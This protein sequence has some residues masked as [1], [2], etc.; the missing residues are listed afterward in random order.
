MDFAIDPFE[1]RGHSRMDFA[2]DATVEVRGRRH[3]RGPMDTQQN[4]QYFLGRVTA[5]TIRVVLLG[6]WIVWCLQIVF[7]FVIPILWGAI[8]ATSILPLTQRLFPKRPGLG[9]T[10]F[11]VVAAAVVI[12]P[13]WLLL[14][15]IG[16]FAVRV[17]HQWAEGK[18]EIP[19]PRAE[20][21][22]WPVIGKRLHA[23]WVDLVN[24][25]STVVERYLPQLRVAGRWLMQSLGSLTLGVLESLFAVALATAFIAKAEATERALVPIAERIAPKYGQGML[26]LA[27]DTV[28]GVAK[29]VLGVALIQAVLAWIGMKVAGVPVPGA[30]ALLVLIAAVAQ[31]PT[32][33]IL[34][35]VAIYVFT[36]SP[37]STAVAFLVWILFV[38]VIDNV[39]KPLLLGRGS[40]VPTLVIVVGA[41][42]GMLSR[43]IIGLFVGAVVLAV[44]YEL[45][46]AW[47]KV[48][49]AK[50]GESQVVRE[51]QVV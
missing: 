7:P 2:I 35:P 41:I 23:L 36:S 40:R 14:G 50:S 32:I 49:E 10:C 17:G 16:E 4:E 8:I 9:A 45:F 19:P 5:A 46:V 28:R 30:W 33:L 12:V 22:D 44:G 20:V 34:G 47:V 25:P 27:R 11:G 37:T 13:S 51:S 43:G 3:A 26:D 29:G 38:G 31:L 48:S 24:A 1:A 18:L 39:L 42:G 15:S 6:A 21:A